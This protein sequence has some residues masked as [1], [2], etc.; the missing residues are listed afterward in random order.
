M[1]AAVEA[2]VHTQPHVVI[3]LYFIIIQDE[4]DDDHRS[5]VTRIGLG[6]QAD[7]VSS[8]AVTSL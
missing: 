2:A 3:A 4:A 5:L 1:A 6:E 8:T 7:G